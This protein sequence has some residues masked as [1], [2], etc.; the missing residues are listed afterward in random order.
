MH[1]I[2]ILFIV[3]NFSCVTERRKAGMR[4]FPRTW[5]RDP[6]VEVA[7]AGQ[8]LVPVEGQAWRPR[9]FRTVIVWPLEGDSQ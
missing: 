7:W 2:N 5:G 8:G 3:V 4:L 9:A 1:T 6:L